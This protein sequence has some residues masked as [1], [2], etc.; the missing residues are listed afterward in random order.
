VSPIRGERDTLFN[1]SIP[2]VML[3][4]STPSNTPRKRSSDNLHDSITPVKTRM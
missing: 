1:E 4:N 2:D 3:T